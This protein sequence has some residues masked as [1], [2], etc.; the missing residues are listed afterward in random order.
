[1]I[2]FSNSSQGAGVGRLSAGV[3]DLGT[4]GSGRTLI[5][6]EYINNSNKWYYV[7]FTFDQGDFKIYIDG[8][9]SVPVYDTATNITTLYDSNAPITIGS[10]NT[11]AGFVNSKISQ[12]SIYNKA[13]SSEEIRQNFEATKGRFGL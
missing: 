11:G 1:M 4:G 6:S 7:G 5:S 9:I 2:G 3:L 10:L 12:V 8:V 13:L